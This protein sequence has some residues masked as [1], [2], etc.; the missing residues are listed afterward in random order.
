MQFSKKRVVTGLTAIMMTTAVSAAWGSSHREAPGITKSPKVDSTDFYLFRSYERQ[1]FGYVTLIANYQP[2][3]A[4]Y[5][6]PNY[7]TMDSDAIYEIHV[8]NDGDA[9]EDITFQFDFTNR[10]AGG[11]GI[12]LPIG[13]QNVAIPLRQA[14]QIT[15]TD[16]GAL[17]EIETYTVNVIRGDRRS[18]R[19]SPLTRAGNSEPTFVKPVDYIGTKTL[20]AYEAYVDRYIY[21]VDIPGC[22]VPGK[23]FVGQRE[24][25]FA[26]NLGGVFDLVNIV[27]IQGESSAEYPAYNVASPFPGGITQDRANDDLVDKLNVTSL[28]L[29]VPIFCLTD[30]DDP[31]I[32]AWTSASLPQAEIQDPSPSYEATS[33]FGGA[34]VQQSRLSAPLVNELVIG[35]PDKDLFNAAEPMQD[36]ALATYVTNPTLPALLDLLFRDAVGADSNI[37]PSNLPRQDLVTAFLTGFPGLNQPANVTASEMLRLNTAITP[38]PQNGQSPFG[39][40]GEDLAGFPN[41]RR[42]GDDVTD[43]ALRVVMGRLCHP[44][45]LGAELGVEGAEEDTES[46]LI[47]LGLCVPGDAPVGTAPFTDGAPI[48]AME[49]QG[50]FPYLNTPLPGAS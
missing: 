22:R 38:T 25:A 2:L 11:T 21:E 23:L 27:P 35:L 40:L 49:M 33:R 1:R 13:D 24:E 36:A 6:G 39:V 29:E 48:T 10:L 44:V 43:L 46:D 4:P 3:Q 26:V 17:N 45:P 30:G 15:A 18:G 47:N 37:A 9:I 42:P 12:T 19:A 14:G 16:T 31:V 28:A 50:T 41:G 8:D 20:P 32:G 7:F 5:G 34:F